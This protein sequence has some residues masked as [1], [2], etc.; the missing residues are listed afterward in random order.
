MIQAIT[1]CRRHGKGI[2]LYMSETVY[3]GIDLKHAHFQMCDIAA[4]TTTIPGEG[5]TMVMVMSGR[6]GAAE[7]PDEHLQQVVWHCQAVT[8]HR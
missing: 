4:M 7:T 8:F 6:F 5:L 2:T 3:L 1:G